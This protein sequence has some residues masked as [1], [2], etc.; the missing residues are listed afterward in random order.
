VHSLVAGNKI[1]KPRARKNMGAVL[2][3]PIPAAEIYVTGCARIEHLRGGSMRFTLV[4]DQ[5]SLENE[6][7]V[8]R[9]VKV[10]V[11]VHAENVLDISK[12]S[13]LAASGM[14]GV[15]GETVVELLH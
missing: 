2:V 10:R 6:Q 7:I 5:Q 14:E 11:V 1:N 12:A 4:A 8:L 3:E 15:I 13:Y 9:V